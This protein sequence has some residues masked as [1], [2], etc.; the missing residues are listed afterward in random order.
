[1]RA[2]PPLTL[3]LRDIYSADVA[4]AG[5]K[6]STLGEIWR[7]VAGA[8][9]E[10]PP[11]FA[12]TTDAY[13][14]FLREAGIEGEL[15]ALERDHD[16]PP[17]ARAAR[18]RELILNAP[19]SAGSG[20]GKIIIAALAAYGLEGVNSFGVRTSGTDEDGAQ[21][22]F[23]GAGDTDLY[24]PP[25]ELLAHVKEVWA[26]LWNVRSL[27]YRRTRGLPTENLAQAVVVQTMIDC[28]VSGV[29]FTA[30]PVSGDSSRLVVD[31][32]F[33]LGEGVVSGQISP[34]QFVVSKLS[35]REILPPIISDK[36]F[37]IVRGRESRGT[38]ERRVPPE[39]RR[40][41]SM[42][43]VQLAKLN[44]VSRALERHFGY[45]L[46]IEF[47]FVGDRL[48]ILQVRPMT[49]DVFGKSAP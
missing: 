29:A 37:E 18:A 39:R 42:T 9:G 33:G 46:D 23:A 8:G 5:G 10:V 14:A 19:L 34:D 45:A 1:M 26:S 25:E 7:I 13:R 38:Q 35:S 16:L 48:Y 22:A 41:R 36:K 31:A 17:A 6:G 49:G 44:R 15:A 32:A 28:D 47:G 20:V 27:S 24:V 2:E 40:R 21:A 11:G 3:L 30:D 43:P 4:R 12:L